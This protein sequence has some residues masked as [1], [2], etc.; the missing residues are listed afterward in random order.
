LQPIKPILPERENSQPSI[1]PILDASSSLIRL[2]YAFGNVTFDDNISSTTTHNLLPNLQLIPKAKKVRSVGDTKVH[3]GSIP[4]NTLVLDSG[5]T[6]NLMNNPSFLKNIKETSTAITIHCGGATVLNNQVGEICDELRNLPLPTKDYFFHPTGV[7]NL[8]SLARVSKEHRVVLDTAIENAFYVYADDGS[9]IKFELNK[10]NLYCLHVDDGSSPHTFLTTVDGKSKSYSDLDVRRATLARDIQNRLVLPS[11]VDFANSLENGTIQE[12]GINRRDIRIAKDIFG[13]NGNSLEGKTVQRKSKLARSDEVLDLPRHIVDKYTNVT[14]AIDVMHVNGNKFLIA[15]SEHIKYIQTIAIAA[16]NEDNF[17]SGI[18]KMVS[19]YQLRGFKVTHILADNAFDCC[20]STL[21][22]DPFN[23]KL[24]TCD[25]DGHVQIIERA[26]RF[27][28]DRIRGIRA[29]M[30]TL[31]FKRLPRRFLIEVVYKTV[32]LIN[33]LMRKGGVSEFLSAREIVTGRKLRLP[34]HEIGQFVHAS[35]GE[36]SNLT[37]V[38]RTFESLYIGRND[39]GSGHYVFDIRTGCRKSA[40][41]VTPLPMPQRVTDRINAMGLHDKQPEDIVIGDRNDQQTVNDF[42]VGLEENEED[43]DDDATD[44]SFDPIK[45]KDIEQAGDHDVDDYAEEEAQHDYFP[46]NHDDDESSIESEEAGVPGGNNNDNNDDDPMLEDLDELDNNNNNDNEDNNVTDDESNEEYI[47]EDV[48]EYDDD[49]DD[50]DDDDNSNNANEPPRGLDNTLDG[51][52][53]SNCIHTQYCMSVISG[54]GN[55]EATL[56]TPQYGF[57]KGLKMFGEGGYKATIKE[58][59][60]NL[61]GRNVIDMLSPEG[62]TRDIFKMSLGYL[63]FLKRKRCGKIKAR[64]CADGRP[65][66]EYITKDQSSSPTVANNAL[67]ATCLVDAIE[68]RAVA[69]CDIPGAFLQADWPD[70]EPCYIRFEGVMV[71]MICQIEPKYIKCIKYGRNKRKWM[72]GKLSKAIYGTLLGARLFYDKL[73]GILEEWGFTINNYDECTF[74]KMVN[75]KQL[76]V[77]FHVD[78]LKISHMEEDV[79][80]NMVK[81]LNG[82]FGQDGTLLEASYG[83]VHEYLGMTIDYSE[84][85]VVKF[86]M[87]DYLEDILAES[88]DDMKGVAVTPAHSK[89][90]QVNSECD[91]LDTKTMDWFHRTV[92]RLLFASKRARPDLQTAVAYLCTRVACPD[93]DDYGKLKKLIEYLRESI[94]LPLILGWDESGVLTWSVDASFAVHMDMRSHTGMALTLGRGALISGSYKQKIN[95]KSSTESELVGVDDGMPF[96]MWIRLFYIEQ[97]KSYPNDH[98]MKEIGQKNIILQDNTST[99]QLENNGKRS[100][101]KRTRH[102]NIRYFYITDQIKEGKVSVTYCPTLEMVSDYFTKP[103]QGSLFRTHRNAIMGLSE[104]EA[105]KFKIAYESAKKHSQE[106][107]N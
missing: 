92:A 74:N 70:N 93:K 90:F 106:E 45:D 25:K 79:I 72:I 9:Y 68:K 44:E 107:G 67:F 83:K 87:Y 64:G 33:S 80:K 12:C 58:L 15:I 94:Y 86:T 59:D 26:I 3:R 55:L 103:L 52:H 24:T 54:Y 37:D 23:I 62:I 16:K 5:A 81:D 20:R 89:L 11:D 49:D 30:K 56:S 2:A 88:P 28:K 85:S 69:I 91:K 95:T 32:I 35:V 84:E 65:Q 7:A 100:S 57:Q 46:N 39:N 66:R 97:F 75:G 1:L 34:P 17:L 31:K 42:N 36:T 14:L 77:Q 71:D 96:I 13:P 18:K 29:M 98:P 60:A 48:D 38:Y 101:G 8:L 61:I 22:A 6:V 4:L 104:K 27:V 82:I 43:D 76:T 50:D 51:P 10:N 53:W 19:Q 21:E 41:R 73:R 63:M 102:I 47:V 78:D 40:G 105:H 99:I